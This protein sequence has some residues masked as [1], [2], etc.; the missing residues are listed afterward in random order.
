MVKRCELGC[1][2]SKGVRVLDRLTLRRPP[3]DDYA[4]DPTGGVEKPSNCKYVSGVFFSHHRKEGT[5][6]VA[7]S[8]TRRPLFY[9]NNSDTDA[10][11]RGKK[12]NPSKQLRH[13]IRKLNNIKFE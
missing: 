9:V 8:V 1:E 4:S 10:S 6:S 7:R 11:E 3:P 12:K 5:E 2:L 13:E